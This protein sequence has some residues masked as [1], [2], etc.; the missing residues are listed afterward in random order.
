MAERHSS[1]L[2]A[3]HGHG[4]P[5]AEIPVAPVAKILVALAVLGLVAAALM[6]PLVHGFLD[7]RLRRQPAT[8]IDAT[9]PV[10]PLLQSRPEEELTVF[11]ARER[12]ALGS[13]GWIDE[14]AG[15]ARIPVARAAELVLDQ[16]LAPVT[17]AAGQPQQADPDAS[18]AEEQR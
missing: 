10:G 4:D 16:G 5:D 8:R 18:A 12:V 11:R 14:A 7:A 1:T 2:P 3:E 6:W 13:Y 9:R 17:A 15:I